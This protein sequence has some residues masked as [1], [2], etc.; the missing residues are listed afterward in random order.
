MST[1]LLKALSVILPLFFMMGVIFMRVTLFSPEQNV[2]GNAVAVIV[3]AVGAILFSAFIFTIIESRER[4]IQRRSQQ[5]EALHQAALALT[6]ELDLQV[7]LQKVVDLSR[8]LLHAKFGAL[9]I[10]GEDEG[11]IGQFFTSGINDGERREIG[12]P[13]MG[14]GLLDLAGPSREPL[15]VEDIQSD[16]RS[17]GFP[18]A[19]P[20]MKSLLGVPIESKGEVLG[21][22][23]LA[24]KMSNGASAEGGELAFTESDRQLLEK[25]ATQAAIAI[26]NAQLYRKTQE[27]AV[28]QER[29]RFSMD[30]HDGIMQSVYATG[31]SL[32]EVKLQMDGGQLDLNKRVEGAIQDLSQVLRDIRN[33]IMGLRPGRFQEQNIVVGINEIALELRANT[34]LNVRVDSL[35]QDE[36]EPWEGEKTAE[37]LFI[38]QEALTNIRKHSHA[39]NVN[40]HLTHDDDVLVLNIEDDGIGFDP[41]LLKKSEGHGLRNMRE[42]ARQVGASIEILPSRGEGTRIKLQLPRSKE[43]VS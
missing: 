24:N 28:L 14:E 40:I 2:L 18:M 25:F 11:R 33:Y 6:N 10:Q 36:F 22:L 30:M 32:Q 5:L 34:L 26:E 20:D 9:A 19:H 15:I 31:L 1:R 13:P 39:R 17:V 42:R 4:E 23:Y 43:K 38:T 37:L 3:V 12:H 35:P 7:V 41:Q 21:N 29:E 27:L 8:E 16:P